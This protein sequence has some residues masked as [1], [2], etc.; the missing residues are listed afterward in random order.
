MLI[1]F[2]RRT[3]YQ[4]PSKILAPDILKDT[5]LASTTKNNKLKQRKKPYQIKEI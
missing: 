2:S 3:A 4:T 1:D 5:T